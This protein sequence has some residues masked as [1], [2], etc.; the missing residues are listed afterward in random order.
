MTFPAGQLVVKKNGG[1]EIALAGLSAQI[2]PNI[3]PTVVDME[4]D[5][6]HL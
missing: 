6:A 5:E 2:V 1:R 4:L 3:S